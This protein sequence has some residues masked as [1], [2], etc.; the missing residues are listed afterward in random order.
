MIVH[1]SSPLAQTSCASDNNIPAALREVPQWVCWKY[2]RKPNRK[3]KYPKLPINPYTGKLASVNDPATWATYAQAAHYARRHGFGVGLVLTPDLGI[4]VI[5]LDDAI[6]PAG[7]LSAFAQSIVEQVDGWTE[8]SPSG[9]GLHIF[10]YGSIPTSIRQA[11]IEIY[12][13]DRYITL[14]GDRWPGTPAEIPNRAE[15]V[16]AL[17]ASLAGQ[18]EPAP[19]PAPAQPIDVDDAQL[20]ARMLSSRHGEQLRR[21]WAGDWSEHP[22]QSEADQALCNALSFWTGRDPGRIDQL[23]RQSGLMRDKWEVASYSES[24]I[25]KA[26]TVA[27]VYTP[28]HSDPLPQFTGEV[29]DIL[30]FARLVVAEH[31]FTGRHAENQQRVALATIQILDRAAALEAPMSIRH[32][33]V[34]AGMGKDTADR[35]MNGAWDKNKRQRLNGGLCEWLVERVETGNGI[36]AN[37]YRLSPK[38]IELYKNTAINETQSEAHAW[39]SSLCLIYRGISVIERNMTDD[40]FMRNR[41]RR[42]FKRE[43]DHQKPDGGWSAVDSDEGRDDLVRMFGVLGAQSMELLLINGEMAIGEIAAVIDQPISDVA[44]AVI[45]LNKT[46]EGLISFVPPVT[47]STVLTLPSNIEQRLQTILNRVNRVSGLS[48]L[49]Q[50]AV[51][52]DAKLKSFT[53]IGLAIVAA[54]EVENHQPIGKLAERLDKHPQVIKAAV[55]RMSLI[56]ERHNLEPIVSIGFDPKDKRSK[57]ISL[58]P[59]WRQRVTSARS[60]LATDGLGRA[61]NIHYALERIARVRSALSHTGNPE[62]KRL[63]EKIEAGAHRVIDFS[64]R[65][66]QRVH[67]QL[68]QIEYETVSSVS[69]ST[70]D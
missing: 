45:L 42:G 69:K 38:I 46:H 60:Q 21:L 2:G 62:T 16:A 67:Q 26:L 25:A 48:K 54:L 37:I 3:G 56:L 40:A 34:L 57:V 58:L 70:D 33:A 53:P 28:Q 49:M 12:A 19:E 24:T 30:K 35:A 32:L 52:D 43:L 39:T 36:T 68:D 9:R 1:Q 10:V 63:F 41:A 14:T 50:A 64:E 5:D 61:R 51:E 47:R 44:R 65:G 6:T 31:K 18:T 11:A 20:I 15:Q 13:C 29:A 55:V 4:V 17:Y 22:S 27:T 23:F 8:V 59:D 7:E 66:L